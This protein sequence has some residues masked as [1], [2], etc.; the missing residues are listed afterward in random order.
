MRRKPR[1]FPGKIEDRLGVLG[2]KEG[3]LPFR[4]REDRCPDIFELG[5]EEQN[6]KGN[7]QGYWHKRIRQ[8][9]R[10]R[11]SLNGAV[12]LAPDG[13]TAMVS[14]VVVPLWVASLPERGTRCGKSD[15]GGVCLERA[16]WL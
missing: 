16:P 4:Y 9:A 6:A 5:W 14:V 8:R 1:V 3:G 10:P 13:Q 12:R 15:Q 11:P 7:H 2:E